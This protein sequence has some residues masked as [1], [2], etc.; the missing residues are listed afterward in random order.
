M[1][2]VKGNI[3]SLYLFSFPLV[4]TNFLPQLRS[5]LI[6]HTNLHATVMFSTTSFTG[7]TL[8]NLDLFNICN[9]QTLGKPKLLVFVCTFHSFYRTD[10]SGQHSIFMIPPCTHLTLKL[11]DK[12]AHA[13]TLPQQCL[14]SW[15]F[16]VQCYFSSGVV[17]KML[18]NN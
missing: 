16:L 13:S 8:Y 10:V 3:K 9:F 17:K 12:E 7:H 1:H 14:A 11:C 4:I 15:V 5:T 2:K 18:I 6:K